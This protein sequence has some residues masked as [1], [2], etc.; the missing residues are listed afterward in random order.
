MKI[1]IPS[2]Q[3]LK[4]AIIGLGLLIGFGSYETSSVLL[5]FIGLGCLSAFSFDPILTRVSTALCVF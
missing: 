4:F 1:P 2:Q 3:Q 5:L